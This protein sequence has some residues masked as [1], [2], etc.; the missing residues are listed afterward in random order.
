MGAILTAILSLFL[1]FLVL[2]MQIEYREAVY[3]KDTY[4]CFRYLNK[5]TEDYVSLIT[6]FNWAIRSAYL[7][8]FSGVG[9]T[10]AAATFKGLVSARNIAH[11]SYVKNLI[12][13]TY[14]SKLESNN[15]VKNL[16]YKTTNL[17]ILDCKKDGTTEVR[18]K[19]WINIIAK[20]PSKIRLSHLFAIKIKYAI[21]GEFFPNFQVRSQEI[22]M[23][24]L[25][26]LN[27]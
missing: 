17:F 11:I 3:R 22:S 12:S 23:Q 2:K 14:C 8:Q 16:P 4:L 24:D 5:Q 18:D 25:P 27:H 20:I 1:L 21:E 19:E 9:S 6:R 15:F 7:A 13:N 26:N 10:Q